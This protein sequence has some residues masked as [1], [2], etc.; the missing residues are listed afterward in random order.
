MELILISTISET[1]LT[2]KKRILQKYYLLS[3][4]SLVWLMNFSPTTK[5]QIVCYFY[6][7]LKTRSLNK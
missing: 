6:I 2:T 1:K 4:K 3:I 5:V 7:N